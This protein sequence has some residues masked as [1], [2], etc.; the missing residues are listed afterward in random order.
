M[1]RG[2]ICHCLQSVSHLPGIVHQFEFGEERRSAHHFVGIAI[3]NYRHVVRSTAPH[4]LK[5][6]CGD[7]IMK[8]ALIHL[9]TELTLKCLFGDIANFGKL[10]Q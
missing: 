7:S 4:L 10:T 6:L 9:L 2:S 5:L 3:L 1:S 8:V